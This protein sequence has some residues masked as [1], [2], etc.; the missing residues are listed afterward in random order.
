MCK[1]RRVILSSDEVSDVNVLVNLENI[2]S[3]DI[4]ASI[5]ASG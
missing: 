4:E 2:D 1:T 3:Y 5:S